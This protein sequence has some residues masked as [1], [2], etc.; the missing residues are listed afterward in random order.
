MLVTSLCDY[1]CYVREMGVLVFVSGLLVTLSVVALQQIA[2]LREPSL[3]CIGLVY[4]ELQ[5][6]VSQVE[7]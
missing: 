3:Q 7:G 4:D 2:R 1:V 6:I 5:R